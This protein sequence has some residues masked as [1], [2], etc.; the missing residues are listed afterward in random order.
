MS[1]SLS[2]SLSLSS[3]VNRASVREIA[4][5]ASETGTKE[6]MGSPKKKRIRVFFEHRDVH[7]RVGDLWPWT[8]NDKYLD[9]RRARVSQG[10]SSFE[11]KPRRKLSAR[12][13]TGS[14]T[15]S[16]FTYE[17]M[18]HRYFRPVTQFPVACAAAAP[19]GKVER[20]RGRR[21]RGR[22]KIKPDRRN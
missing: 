12:V 22:E 2:L 7:S 9:S 10:R 3:L 16:L 21:G 8:R 5:P 4:N 14:L 1:L 20:G 19:S 15:R 6:P 17:I 18:E 13:C 11:Q